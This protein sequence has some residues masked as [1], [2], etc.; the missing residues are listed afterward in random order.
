MKFGFREKIIVAG[1]LL[2]LIVVGWYMLYYGP[3]NDEITQIQAEIQNI[4]RSI[5]SVNVTPAMIDSL[6]NEV[7]RLQEEARSSMALSVDP[8]SLLYVQNIITSKIIEYDLERIGPIKPNIEK[9]FAESAQDSLEVQTG[10]R[11]V[12]IELLL[13]GTFYNLVE[14]LDSFS[15]FPFLI[16]ASEV[17]VDTDDATYPDLLIRLKIFVFFG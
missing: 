5:A 11:P 2:V 12:D 8:D 9:L 10:I 7:Q 3:K 1:S 13:R 16:R 14:F 15:D 4:Q 6:R 17:N